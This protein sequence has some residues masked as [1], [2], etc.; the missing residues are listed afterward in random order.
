MSGLMRNG[1]VDLNDIIANERHIHGARHGGATFRKC[2][3]IIRTTYM[4]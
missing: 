2:Y 4:F 1:D 3:N